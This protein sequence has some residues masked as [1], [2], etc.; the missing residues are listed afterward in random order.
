MR[1]ISLIV[2]IG[3]IY[4]MASGKLSEIVKAV[5]ASAASAGQK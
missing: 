4:L 3:L 1:S 2:G 5:K